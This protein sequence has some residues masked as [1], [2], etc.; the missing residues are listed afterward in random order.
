[1]TSRKRRFEEDSIHIRLAAG[2]G[3]AGPLVADRTILAA[4]SS[5]V[6]GLPADSTEWDISNLVVEGQAVDRPTVVAMLNAM[7][8]HIICMAEPLEKQEVD[9][10]SNMRGLAFLLAFADAVGCS[11]GLLLCLSADLDQLVAEVQGT[12]CSRIATAGGPEPA[13]AA[14]NRCSE[15]PHHCLLHVSRIGGLAPFV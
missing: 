15:A 2:D 5:C 14:P 9:A 7:Y 3:D 12:P 10:A 13:T 11:R 6:R 4:L 1:M 8:M